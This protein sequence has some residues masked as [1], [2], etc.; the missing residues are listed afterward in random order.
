MRTFLF[1]VLLGAVAGIMYAPATGNRTRAL[2]RDK[3]NQL[4]NDIPD[5]L[6]SKGRDLSNRMEGVKSNVN[7]AI[8]TARPRVERAAS[9]VQDAYGKVRTDVTDWGD[10]VVQKADDIRTDIQTR[11]A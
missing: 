10:Q 1:G 9:A 3:A 2:L 8:E 7:R 6:E 11:S 5:L 4:S